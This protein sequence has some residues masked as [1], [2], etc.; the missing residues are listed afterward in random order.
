[1]DGRVRMTKLLTTADRTISGLIS[2]SD[3][4]PA[5]RMVCTKS[6]L[7]MVRSRR[8]AD[9]SLLQDRSQATRRRVRL[10][11]RF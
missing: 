2:A 6:S 3:V 7:S 5:S 11:E 1:M 4:Q 9:I 10:A 8:H